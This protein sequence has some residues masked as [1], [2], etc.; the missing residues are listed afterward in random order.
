VTCLLGGNF[1]LR[2]KDL[3][4]RSLQRRTDGAVSRFGPMS[5]VTVRVTTLVFVPVKPIAAM[6]AAIGGS[7]S[8]LARVHTYR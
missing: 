2:G 1:T 8:V 7:L 5:P 6:A 3:T 4:D